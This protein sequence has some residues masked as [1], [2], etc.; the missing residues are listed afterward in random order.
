MVKKRVV[1]EMGTF[2][3]H[4]G[5]GFVRTVTGSAWQ[6]MLMPDQPSVRDASG[7]EERLKAARPM[8]DILVGL[9]DRTVRIPFANRKTARNFYRHVHILAVSASRPFE[10]SESL[11]P[12]NRAR[13]AAEEGGLAVHDRFTL[14]GVRLSTGGGKGVRGFLQSIADEDGW[15][16]DTA[17]DDDRDRVRELMTDAGCRLPDE[18][19]MRRA[20]AFW[21][22]DRKPEGLPV[23]IEHDHMHTF[24]SYRAA[25][26]AARF[27]EKVTDCRKWSARIKGSYPMTV[28][29]LGVLPFKGEAN[30][31]PGSDW[32][33][34]LLSA[35]AGRAVALSI[36]GL[37]EPGDM[38]REQIDKDTEKVLD[39][40][41]EQAAG[42]RKANLGVAGELRAAN[43]EYQADGKPWPTLIEVHAH[44]AIPAIVE[45]AQRVPYPGRLTLNP[46]RQDSAFEDMQIGSDDMIEYNPS[47]CYWP[48][49]ILA[50]AG[51]NGKGVTGDDSGR[52]LASDLPGAFVGLTEADRQPVY[53]SPFAASRRSSRPLTIC[54]GSTGSGKMEQLDSKLVVPPQKRFPEGGMARIG[55]L[56]EGD[57]LY[58]RDGKTYPILMLHPIQTRDVYELTLS[59]GQTFRVGGDHQWPVWSWNDRRYHTSAKH[60]RSLE[61]QA[62]L[63]HVCAG[64]RD[65]AARTPADRWATPEE[66]WTEAGPVIGAF[67]G[68]DGVKWTYDALHFADV[69]AGERPDVVAT[70]RKRIVCDAGPLL[71]WLRGEWAAATVMPSG[72]RARRL[73]RADELIAAG[74]DGDY[75]LAELLRDFTPA[76]VSRTVLRTALSRYP[77]EHRTVA[78]GTMV[79]NHVIHPVAA[80]L[81]AL[82]ERLEW[83]YRDEG[84]ANTQAGSHVE[85]VITT[86]EMLHEGL[87]ADGGQANWAIRAPKPMEGVE[88]DLP[89]D[90]WC[91][92]AWLADGSTGT[93]QITSD[94]N[95][96][97]LD[98]ARGRFEKAGYPTSTLSVARTFGTRGLATDLRRAGV[99]DRKHIPEIYQHASIGQ[100]LEL[101]RGLLDQD[102]TIDAKG[103][104]EFNQSVDHAEIVEGLTRL[105]RS[106]GIVVHKATRSR[107]GYTLDGER[108]EARDR[109]CL[110]FTTDLPVF[111]LPRK[112]DRLP[113]TVRETRKWLYVKDIRP[114]ADA[115]CRCL[116][117]GSPDHT[118]LTGQY[119]PT[120][121]TRLG[122]HIAA[123]WGRL[124]DPEHK[125][126]KIPV[127]FWDPKPKSSDFEPFVRKRGGVVT[128]LD[129]ADAKGILDPFR[130]I[131]RAMPDMIVQTAVA[132]LS[133]ITGGSNPERA[134]EMGITSVVGFGLRRGVDCLGEAVRLAYEEYTGGGPEANTISP[135][136][137]KIKPDLDRAVMNDPLMPLIYGTEPGGRR[138]SISQGL[139]LIS[140]GTLNVI[141]DKE[142]Q[143]APTDVQRWVCRMAALG[144]SCLVIGRNGVVVVDEAWSLLQDRFGQSV[145]NRMG[146]LAR[147]Q[148]YVVMML[149]QKADEFVNAGVEDFVGK[150]YVLAI[151][152]RN[153]GAGRDSQAQAAC[154]LANQPLD[155]RMHARMMHDRYLDPDS[156]APDW[157]SLYPLKDPKTGDLL[158]GSVAYMQVGDAASAIPV[159]I[160]IDR[161]LD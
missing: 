119:V 11:D 152:A 50:F 88:T 92:G 121:N 149:S 115:P 53:D 13:L 71:E 63:A 90:P 103:A 35:A 143:G 161:S 108:H 5:D 138:L 134:W 120:H 127:V 2:A 110:T 28:C 85:Q 130:C 133:Q 47:P 160:R 24:P 128:K 140:A 60:R 9:A 118:Y 126:E 10:P 153:E 83:R 101:V 139:T 44:A 12:D 29:T 49:P 17:F 33:A 65:M 59:D 79:K 157:E 8:L 87:L 70:T 150:V 38:S 76:G 72:A 43:E 158:R 96:G 73:A 16:P 39:K 91:L 3:R 58:C 146:R 37:V 27:R 147:D 112:R 41:Y 106:L 20:M 66:I 42:G 69:P 62:A 129:T 159:E 68:R 135:L 61:R 117:V 19:T 74:V 7:E 18:E 86:R 97:D 82:A 57:L 30:T 154:R 22:T 142:I 148:H 15:V 89:V 94:P 45:Q 109:L 123:Q 14:F 1:R 105:L 144:A 132:M 55:D 54:L 67:A 6:Y 136:I 107:A 26:M 124:P 4:M 25:F 48:A 36:K 52:G 95:N 125:G 51:I 99:L 64:L 156:R 78:N 102:G 114:V 137:E 151:G 100:R 56:K 84:A 81:E 31:A 93:G 104:I 23:M 21:P 46:D 131:P 145:V 98:H 122:L 40:A 34:T 155:G 32:A 141:T 80:A 75:G 77:G 113:K 116:T 111:S